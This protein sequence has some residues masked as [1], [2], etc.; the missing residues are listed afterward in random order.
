MRH[1]SVCVLLLALCVSLSGCGGGQTPAAEK[2]RKAAPA[3]PA[4]TAA[5]DSGK[6]IVAGSGTNL[7]I[8]EKLAA[9]F[10]K[11]T[12]VPVEVPKSIG[13]DGAVKAVGDGTIKLGL[14]SRPLSDAEKATGLKTLPYAVVGIV[15]AVNPA[16]SESNVTYEDILRIHRGEKTEWQ[17][18]TRI[19]VLIRGMHDSSNQILFSFIPGFDK[20]IKESVDQKRWLVMSHDIDMANTLRTKAGS[21][22]HTDTTEIAVRGG[23]KPLSLNGVAPTAENMESGKYVWVKNLDFLYKGELTPQARAFVEFAQSPDGKAVIREN[24]GAAAR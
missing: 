21:F 19:L 14:M 23:I 11:K 24:G 22:G 17:D 10:T 4:A 18:G 1:R 16:T 5:A 12:G 3:A 13:S 2:E 20:L 9:A 8:T 7:P 6:L 15:F